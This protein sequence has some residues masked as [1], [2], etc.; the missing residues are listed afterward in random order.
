[1]Y[2]GNTIVE[3]KNKMLELHAH[4]TRRRSNN[5]Q[6]YKIQL[7]SRCIKCVRKSRR[8]WKIMRILVEYSQC[9]TRKSRWNLNKSPFSKVLFSGVV[10]VVFFFFLFS[11]TPLSSHFSLFCLDF[12]LRSPVRGIISISLNYK[13]AW[14]IK[15]SRICRNSIS[16]DDLLRTGEGGGGGEREETRHKT[17]K[18]T[19]THT[20]AHK[21]EPK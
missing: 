7:L 1:V 11:S 3:K 12:F 8:R 14:R 2:T 4:Y 16:V 9:T 10:L 19:H 15:A 17:K 13:N 21:K 18:Q 5:I 20:H 6:R